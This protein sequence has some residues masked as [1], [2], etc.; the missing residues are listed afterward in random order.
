MSSFVFHDPSGRRDRRAAWVFGLLAAF[1][2]LLMAGFAMTLA[3]APELPNVQFL[4]PRKLSALHPEYHR[5]NE[6]P[7]AKALQKHKGSRLPATPGDRPLTVGFYVTYDADSRSSLQ[8]HISKLDVLAPQWMTLGSDQGAVNVLPDPFGRTLL[9]NTKKRPAVVALIINAANEKWDGPMVERLLENPQARITLIETLALQADKNDWAGV[10]FDLEDLSPKALALYPGFLKQ[11]RDI[12][13][14][15]GRQ[16]WATMPFDDEEWN[17]PKLQA[18]VDQLVLMAYD[19]HYKTGSPGPVA[20]QGWYEA[21]LERLKKGLDPDHTI[22]ALG[23]YGFDWY[24]TG[25]HASTFHEA[26]LAASDSQAE[27]GF[28]PRSLN[29]TFS[30]VE[31]GQKHTYWF[32]DAVTMF[33]Q[34]QVTDDWR[35]RGY[36]VWRLGMED[37]GVWSLLGQP[38]GEASPDGLRLLQAGNDVDFDGKGEVLKVVADP[39]DGA[40]DFTVDA[41]SELISSE[42][43]LKAPT[44]Y[45]VRR[46]GFEGHEKQV[47]LTFD[48]GPDG[49][50]TPKIL[51]ILKR[52]NVPATF[53]DLGQ[54]M[55]HRP[56]L[57][58][59]EVR[60]GHEVGS[61]TFTH[62]NIGQVPGAEATLELN[63]TQRLFE[64]ITGKSLRLFRPPFLGDA[65]PSTPREVRQIELAQNLSYITVG[66]RVDPD[67]W[68]KPSPQQIVER[69]LDQLAN[70]RIPDT[71]GRIVLLHDSGGNR[72]ATVAALPGLIDALQAHGYTIVTAGQLAGLKPDESMP[73]TKRGSISLMLDRAAF[74][75]VRN[76]EQGLRIMLMT[77]IVLGIARLAFLG[78]FSTI[79]AVRSARKKPP[80]LDE[81]ERPLVSVLIP[82][83]NE[84]AVIESSVRRILASDWPNLEV[85]VLDDGS[86]DATASVVAHAFSD[87]ERVR[88]LRFENGGKARA[89]N[90][91][92]AEARGEIIVALDA[93]TQFPPET[94]G[95]LARWFADPA[96]GAVAGNALVGNRTNLIT[97]WQALEYVTAQN[98]ERRAL[99]VLGAVTVVPG[100]VGAWRRGALDSVGGYPT[101]TLAEDQD[102]TIAIQR[103]GWKVTFDSEARAF[104]ESP[105]TVGG[106]LKQR[107]R[108]SFGTLQCLW[109]HRNGL[110]SRKNVALGWVALPQVWLFQIVM[111]VMSPLVDLAVLWSLVSAWM[112]ARSHPVEWS[113]DDLYRSIAF[114]LAFILLD[115][116]AGVVGMIMEPRAPW[117]ELAWLPA[118]RFGYRQMMYYVVIKAVS[119]AVRGRRVGWG[120]LER[121]ATVAVPLKS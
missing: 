94:L 32:L 61:H 31:E 82:C 33:N 4:S 47:A 55:E 40:R 19:E 48:D 9:R 27:I 26:T 71:P 76:F 11:A 87:E 90:R 81:T 29:P 86:A 100:A 93:D 24:P 73:P 46:L 35:P 91:G 78:V 110:F 39:H 51:D 34:I 98:L 65:D 38:Y 21:N 95:R 96:I 107:F 116:A 105:D 75:L 15:H 63:A 5:H 30:Y 77:A 109:K 60:E 108:W 17:A 97:K 74:F 56:D 1:L 92:L 88:L 18:S 79:H 69:V 104:T 2:L 37:E 52:K 103:A 7:W 120:K 101:D 112:A 83:F 8:Q 6:V 3:T 12:M 111:T 20:G 67:D 59:R 85:L 42:R 72:A 25:S 115:L 57:V 102:L 44:A 106:L 68:Q 64:T 118:Q 89:L 13:H 16:V 43:Y 84:E 54:N 113:P 80:A 36:A 99:A 66:L 62:P 58:L 45:T 49:R 119:H 10:G 50:W 28:D 121:K 23:A 22:V 117:K 14:A 114:W 41:K 70:P 53:F